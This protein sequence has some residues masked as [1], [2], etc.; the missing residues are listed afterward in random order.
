MAPEPSS[1]W[2]PDGYHGY[3]TQKNSDYISGSDGVQKHLNL[4]AGSLKPNSLVNVEIMSNPVS[5]GHFEVTS[6]GSLGVDVNLPIDLDEGYHT[7]HLY[8][9]SN[10]GELIELWQLIGFKKPYTVS[11]DVIKPVDDQPKNVTSDSV[12]TIDNEAVVSVKERINESGLNNS[13]NQLMP[14]FGHQAVEGAKIST[15]L[16]LEVGR[17]NNIADIFIKIAVGVFC[18]CSTII[19]VTI[20]KKENIN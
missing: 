8:G 1:Y 3:P 17:S 18:I 9:T 2:L 16:P 10:S 13:Q 11:N 5:L 4:E 20:V 7:I 14:I 6:D 12:K 15:T 19:I